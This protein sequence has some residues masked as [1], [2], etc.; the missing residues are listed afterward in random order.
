M[1][2]PPM[3]RFGMGAGL[4]RTL[5]VPSLGGM[6]RLS[7]GKIVSGGPSF[8]AVDGLVMPVMPIELWQSP[9]AFNTKQMLLGSVS[10]DGMQGDPS[11]PHPPGA[12]KRP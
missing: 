11:C 12:D 3:A 5:G 1:T 4:M 9:V 10:L 7:P 6:M 8:F 2:S